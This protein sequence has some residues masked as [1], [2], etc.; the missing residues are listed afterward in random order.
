MTYK[1][2]LCNT[3]TSVFTLPSPQRKSKQQKLTLKK[4]PQMNQQQQSQQQ[5]PTTP[6]H[7]T[8]SYQEFPSSHQRSPS[9][10]WLI[11]YLGASFFKSPSFLMDQMCSCASA[12]TVMVDSSSPDIAITQS[13]SSSYFD[14][15]ILRSDPTVNRSPTKISSSR[16]E[17][18]RAVAASHGDYTIQDYCAN[19]DTVG[20]C[21]NDKHHPLGVLAEDEV[22]T[23]NAN[24]KYPTKIGRNEFRRASIFADES[25][26]D[27]E[28]NMNTNF[29]A[30]DDIRAEP[31]AS[32]TATAQ[33]E[34][35][36]D[37]NKSASHSG[38]GLETCHSFD[39]YIDTSRYFCSSKPF[40][41]PEAQTQAAPPQS[42]PA[43]S[44]PDR[45]R[46]RQLQSQFFEM[47]SQS[48]SYPISL[49]P[50]TL[51]FQQLAL[52]TPVRTP[53]S[54]ALSAADTY[55]TI[56]LSHSFA[57]E[58]ESDSSSSPSP[59]RSPWRSGF[60]NFHLNRACDSDDESSQ[61]QTGF[62]D[63]LAS[64][65][66]PSPPRSPFRRLRSRSG[67]EETKEEYDLENKLPSTPTRRRKRASNEDEK[68]DD[69][70]STVYRCLVRMSPDNYKHGKSSSSIYD[71]WCNMGEESIR[72]LSNASSSVL[73]PLHPHQRI[74]LPLPQFLPDELESEEENHGSSE[75]ICFRHQ[76]QRQKVSSSTDF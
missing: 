25:K 51:G 41:T 65:T 67:E 26:D 57:R 50:R 56:S 62:L 35:C 19:Y 30:E 6:L 64:E 14:D 20:P 4:Q 13:N 2:P 76:A 73:L 38:R 9:F 21:S 18:L 29:D 24:A 45:R 33:S 8:E 7:S 59:T 12:Q 22:A 53:P 32:P 43:T 74:M 70:D 69:D 3:R 16:W 31:P 23:E 37:L 55:T 39:Q 54:P 27:A 71:D 58:F 42:P 44:L 63:R 47:Q 5:F 46:S 34:S 1:S 36:L 66:T 52:S 68:Q 15:T 40:S 60:S 75:Y 11:E 17:A 28:M 48:Q 61:S 49:A 72:S 10:P